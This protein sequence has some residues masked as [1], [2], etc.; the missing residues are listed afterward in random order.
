[1]HLLDTHVWI[2]SIHNDSCLSAS[3]RSILSNVNADEVFVSAI[4]CWEVSKL[5][6][7]GRLNLNKPIEEWFK[8][9][10]EESGIRVAPLTPE[11]A[12][13]SNQ[14]PKPFHRDPADTIIVATARKL[15]LKLLT[16]DKRILEYAHVE[17]V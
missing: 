7:L 6:S 1:M 9:A 5:V 8:A 3:H 10:L 4:S 16:N 13:E 17:T 2:W 15:G 12:L 11:I 14:L